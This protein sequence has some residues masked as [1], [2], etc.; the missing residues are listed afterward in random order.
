[1]I[2]LKNISTDIL[3]IGGGISGLTTAYFLKDKYKNIMLIDKSNIGN[4]IT[5]KTTA[6]ITYLQGIIY[7]TLEKNFNKKIS[8]KYFNSQKEAI[9]ILKD[10]ITKNKISCNFEKVDSIIFTLKKS[11]ISKIFFAI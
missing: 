5:N 11:N 10:I 4:D 1:M 9:E 8:K 7:K 2:N 6:K 3:I